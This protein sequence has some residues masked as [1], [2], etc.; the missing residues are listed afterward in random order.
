MLNQ[1]IG[2]SR[3][4]PI[5]LDHY[6]FDEI[7]TVDNLKGTLDIN[8]TQSGLRVQANFSAITRAECG[9]CLENFELPLETEFEELFTY[10]HNPLSEDELIIPEDGNINF[11]SY[12]R[13]YVLLEIPINPIC[14]PDCRGLCDI[15]GENL[16]LRECGHEHQKP[17]TKMASAMKSIEGD[18]YPGKN[19]PITE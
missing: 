9:R 12:I 15:C 11:E 1:P 4:I 18:Y 17:L 10:E 16:N 19:S 14:K 5:E 3:D 7:L 6:S 2:Y 13:D 8:R